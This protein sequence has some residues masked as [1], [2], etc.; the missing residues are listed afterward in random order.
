M[1]DP[2]AVH[3]PGVDH[4]SCHLQ[5]A[6]HLE[7]RTGSGKSN[8]GSQSCCSE[9]A[10]S[11]CPRAGQK[12]PS[13]LQLARHSCALP[14][15]EVRAGSFT[16]GGQLE[17]AWFPHEHRRKVSLPEFCDAWVVYLPWT[18]RPSL[19]QYYRVR[20]LQIVAA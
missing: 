8:H 4:Q 19:D 9:A 3:F 7:N 1:I 17:Y 12:D 6:D 10:C 15:S 20:L 2:A 18:I 11:P 14:V 5:S 16:R 13:S